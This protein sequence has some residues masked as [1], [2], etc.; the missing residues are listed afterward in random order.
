M[1]IDGGNN[2]GVNN[3]GVNND[4]VNCL[5]LIF[6]GWPIHVIIRVNGLYRGWSS[7]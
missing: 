2:D 4:G 1:S 6:L 5:S 7:N 3:D